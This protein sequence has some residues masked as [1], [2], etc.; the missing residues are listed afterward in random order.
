MIS[1]LDPRAW[2]SAVVLC[3]ASVGIGYWRGNVAGKAS[4]QASAPSGK[5]VAE[6]HPFTSASRRLPLLLMAPCGGTA[7]T[8]S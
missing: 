7:R 2:I 6:P 4:V 1:I 5:V 8:A 3:V